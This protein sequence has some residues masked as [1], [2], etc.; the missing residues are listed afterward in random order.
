MAKLK[1]STGYFKN[2]LP[3]VCIGNSPRKLVIFSGGP[4]FHHRPPSGLMLRMSISMFKHLA[5]DFTVYYVSRKPGLPAGYSTQDM[6]DDYAS[7]IKDELGG[8]VDII[9]LSSGGPIAQHFAVDHPDLVHHLVL[10]ETGY[11]LSKEGKEWTKHL[12]DLARQGKWRAAAAFIVTTVYPRGVKKHLFKWLMWLFG[13]SVFGA[14]TDPSDG[15]VEVEA[16]V[17]HD[18]KE[19]LGEIKVPTL[20]I[21]GEEDHLYPIRETAAGIPNAK[22]ILYEGLGH[23]AIMKRQFSE[24]VLAFLTE[25]TAE[26]S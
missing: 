17:N 26:D 18:F 13:K 2:G 4:D 10:A 1:V 20:V 5:E 16:E 6:S 3:Y 12:G 22:L 21:G 7:M 14:P 11:A 15:L 8:P 9:G 24:D 25:G 19:R 23:D